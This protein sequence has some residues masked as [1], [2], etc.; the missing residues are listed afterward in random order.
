MFSSPIGEKRLKITKP[1]TKNII[2]ITQFSS[3][4]GE[5][6]LKIHTNVNLIPLYI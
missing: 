5:K 3:P 2:V 1:R 4:I 6:R